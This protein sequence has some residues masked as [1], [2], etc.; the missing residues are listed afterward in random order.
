MTAP[1]I[2]IWGWAF[3]V[4]LR[5]YLRRMIDEAWERP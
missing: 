3:D 4:T 5:F 2:R 1:S